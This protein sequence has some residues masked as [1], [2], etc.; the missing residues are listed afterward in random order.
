LNTT[1]T[2]KQ[3]ASNG[4]TDLPHFG[5][6]IVGNIYTYRPSAYA[7]VFDADQRVAVA[8][9]KYGY[10]FLLGGGAEPSETI[11]E[12]L[13]REVLEEKRGYDSNQ[14]KLLPKN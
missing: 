13:Q 5:E 11:E 8:K 9:N 10:Y 4:P 1:G 6:R 12:T 7:V 3:N 14:G 2:S